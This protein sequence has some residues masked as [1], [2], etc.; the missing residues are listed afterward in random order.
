MGGNVVD[1]TPVGRKGRVI[2]AA[3]HEYGEST[4]QEAD[5]DDEY[6]D[7]GRSPYQDDRVSIS[8]ATTQ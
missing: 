3:Q 1:L 7:G 4:E 2:G 5:G 8:V 6:S